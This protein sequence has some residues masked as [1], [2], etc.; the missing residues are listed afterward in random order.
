MTGRRCYSGR[1]V[2]FPD[3]RR[4]IQRAVA[5]GKSVHT[6]WDSLARPEAHPVRIEISDDGTQGVVKTRLP[7]IPENDMALQLG[8][9]FYQ[10]RA[11]LDCLIYQASAYVEG[12]DPPSNENSVEFPICI[13][14]GKFR[15]NSVNKPPF[16]QELRDWLLSIQPY[17]AND[18]SHP[19]YTLARYLKLLHDY[20]RIDRHRRLHMV[21]AAIF[22]VGVHF[23]ASPGVEISGIEFVGGN[24]FE[25][26]AEFV[27]FNVSGFKS[28]ERKK[29][30]LKSHFGMQIAMEGHLIPEGGNLGSEMTKI[31]HAVDY[32]IRHFRESFGDDF[33]E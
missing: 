9:F 13:D 17:V 2:L 5:H 25:D 20:A 33:S 26:E 8:E 12:I 15:K 7:G 27:R 14:E 32:V 11:A 19:N 4:R 21:G 31:V 3:S 28:S 22:E 29:I 6:E 30:Q 16:P 23:N 18:A 24:L 1:V 10:L